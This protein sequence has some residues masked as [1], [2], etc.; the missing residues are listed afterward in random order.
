M[1]S[2][3]DILQQLSSVQ[4]D[5]EECTV[6]EVTEE[7]IKQGIEDCSNSCLEKFVARKEMNLKGL[8]GAL[9]RAWKRQGFRIF[10]VQ[11]DV[12]QLFFASKKD[13]QFVLSKG[14]WNIDN[15]LLVVK[16]WF[17]G[18]RVNELD[19]EN[20]FFGV[21]ICGLPWEFY[22]Q[23]VAMKVASSFRDCSCVQ[24]KEKSDSDERFFRLRILVNTKTP[25]R[26]VV[27][28][29]WGDNSE[30]RGILRYE[31]LSSFCYQCGV[32]GH[33][34]KVCAKAMVAEA[35]SSQDSQYGFWLITDTIIARQIWQQILSA[36]GMPENPSGPMALE[37]DGRGHHRA[38]PSQTQCRA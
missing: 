29:K 17:S 2:M 5:E 19:F 31:R 16:S 25:L 27:R 23:E 28:L 14:P 15:N 3:Q 38:S 1:S 12:C 33:T 24:L 18:V 30:A 4:L 11:P 35:N 37:E 10:R 34:A 22:T 20:V 36:E 8:K 32:M 9:E 21:N 6:I 26:R 13:L 7:E